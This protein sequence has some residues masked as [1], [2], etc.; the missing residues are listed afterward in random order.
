[1]FDQGL[2]PQHHLN[3]FVQS[4]YLHYHSN[5]W[6]V[7]FFLEEV[8]ALMQQGCITLHTNYSQDIN[9]IKYFFQNI[10]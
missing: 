8:N 10:L 1:M 2:N 5:V 9:K 7:S 3:A 6:S 4:I